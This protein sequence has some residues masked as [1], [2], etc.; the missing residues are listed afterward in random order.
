[1]ED[2]LIAFD[3]AGGDDN[4]SDLE[5]SLVGK[6][7]TV[8]TYNFE[9]LKRTLNQVWAISNGALFRSIHRKR[10]ICGAI[11]EQKG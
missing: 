9:A 3:D 11:C 5:L 1:M 2:Q 6:V 7:L 4:N 10:I 8:R